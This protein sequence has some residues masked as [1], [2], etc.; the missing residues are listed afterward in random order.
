VAIS[1]GVRVIIYRKTS[2]NIGTNYHKI[3]NINSSIFRCNT[4]RD[5]EAAGALARST[6]YSISTAALYSKKS[7]FCSSSS[8]SRQSHLKQESHHSSIFNCHKQE[9]KKASTTKIVVLLKAA[10]GDA[11]NVRSKRY[12][13]KNE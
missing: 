11:I 8:S 4:P 7:T 3:G 13:L 9:V 1:A 10:A 12:K 5:E 2:G 6:L